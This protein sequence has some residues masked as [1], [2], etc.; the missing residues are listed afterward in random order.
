MSRGR[1]VSPNAH[2]VVALLVT[3]SLL[4]LAGCSAAGEPGSDGEEKALIGVT[5]RFIAGNSWLQAMVDGLEEEGTALGYE[6]SSLDAR[7]NAQTQIQQMQTFVARGAKAIILEP[8]DDRTVGPGVQAAIDAGIPVIVIN[9]Q[10]AP[11]LAETVACNVHS[12]QY[13]LGVILGEETAKAVAAKHSSD[14]VLKGFVMSI[15]PQEPLSEARE[16]GFQEGYDGYFAENDG[17]TTT[18][19]EPGYGSAL[20]DETLPIMRDKISA[21]PDVDVVYNLTDTVHGAVMTALEEAGLVNADGGDSKVIVASMDGRMPVIEGMANVD[22]FAVVANSLTAPATSAALAMAAADRAI[23]AGSGN[24]PV[25]EGEIPTQ[26]TPVDAVTTETASEYL[27]E[28]EEFAEP[29]T[30]N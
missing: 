1:K 22:G 30:G 3:G 2:R 21:N 15:L 11:D 18:W 19:I 6:V 8:I 27:E 24:D 26:L 17:P 12:D 25:C 13:A 16:Q 14:E 4:T 29:R 5:S 20:P 9:D 10:L 7:G 23:K 28:G